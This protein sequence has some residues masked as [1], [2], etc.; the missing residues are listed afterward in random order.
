[1]HQ[2]LQHRRHNSAVPE[3]IDLDK[4]PRD[5]AKR[6]RMADY[7]PNQCDQIRR[8][9]WTWGPHQPRGFNFPYKLIGKKR[10]SRRRFNPD[11]FDQYGNWIEYSE[12]TDKAYCLCCYLFRDNVKDN[13]HGHDAFVLQGWN[14]WKKTERLVTHVGDRDSFHNRALKDCWRAMVCS[15]YW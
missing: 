11:W 5:P 8:K 7:H 3:L 6:K 1:M 12:K 10:K 2:E 9:Y 14:F 13:H 15:A 4:L